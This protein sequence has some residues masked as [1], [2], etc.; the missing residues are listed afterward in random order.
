MPVRNNAMSCTVIDNK[1]YLIGGGRC[2][3]PRNVLTNDVICGDLS[4]LLLS[5]EHSQSSRSAWSRL[6]SCPHRGSTAARVGGALIAI[7]GKEGNDRSKN[8]MMEICLYDAS[9]EKWEELRFCRLPEA[10]YLAAVMQLSSGEMLIIGG[11]G[12]NTKNCETTFK[13]SIQGLYN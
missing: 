1:C 3:R 13:A 2:Q 9:K 7:G 10:R 12:D 11:R 6:P 5:I 4:A 8:V